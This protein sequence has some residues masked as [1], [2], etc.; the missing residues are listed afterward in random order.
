MSVLRAALCAALA[1]A[2]A[3]HAQKTSDAASELKLSTA[4]APAFA[5][6]RAGARWTELVN[7]GAAGAFEVRQ[8]PGATLVQR[9]AARE[10]P[11]LR[12][13]AADLAVGSAL[14]WSAQLPALAIFSLPWLAS[15]PRELD[16]LV[17]DPVLQQLLAARLAAEGVVALA[18]APL[19]ERVL[20]TV[21]SPPSAPA[22][23]A[24][25]RIRTVAT[26]ILV[27]TLSALG[28]LPQA[29]SLP[30]AQR[31]FA[32]G[33]LDG[34]DGTAAAFATTHIAASGQKFVA[35]WGAFGDAM[36]FAVR[37]PVW[38]RWS[39]AQRAAVRTAAVRAAQEAQAVAREDAA[40]GELVAQG[41]T[42][43]R[44]TAAQRAAFRAATNDVRDTWTARIGEDIVR[45]ADEVRNGTA[46]PAKPP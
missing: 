26:P 21:R 15:E 12:T 36:V 43:V 42:I 1:L 19:G 2:G 24:G 37:Q 35:R 30:D 13:G 14:A 17:A 34:Q 38:D 18:F 23:L 5:L 40:L 39:D 27:D 9:D 3:A 4:V 29:M 10:L 16:A 28:A 11:G 7:E 46:S 20:A 33:T 22:D 31:M 41:V 32:A 8:Y 6:G 25:M 44:P 45:R